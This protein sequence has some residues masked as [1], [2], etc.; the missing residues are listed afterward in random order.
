MSSE[1]KDS[2]HRPKT[3]TA[4]GP[5][6]ESTRI[7]RRELVD[8]SEVETID[9]DTSGEHTLVQSESDFGSEQ[10]KQEF[11]EE[12]LGSDGFLN[13]WTSQTL[14]QNATQVSQQFVRLAEVNSELT[15]ARESEK[16]SVEKLVEMMVSMRM[17]EKKR[18]EEREERRE[19][20]R[21]EEKAERL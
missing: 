7:R 11:K 17:D 15:M 20:E 2:T 16:S 9:S 6:R 13:T 14:R 5:A 4:K 1:G 19:R 12:T 3:K 8:Y 21:R 18:E 10:L